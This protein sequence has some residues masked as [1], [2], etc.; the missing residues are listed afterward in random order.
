MPKKPYNY[1]D[2]TDTPL[3]ANE[4]ALAYAYAEN[5]RVTATPNICDDEDCQCKE[6]LAREEKIMKAIAQ[7][8]E[9]FYGDRPILSDEEALRSAITID[10]LKERMRVSI[11]NIFANKQ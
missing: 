7:D 10:E 8:F 4:P 3:T 11:H 9:K 6:C 5:S 1:T 2:D